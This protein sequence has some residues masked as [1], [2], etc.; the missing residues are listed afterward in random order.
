MSRQIR[1][2]IDQINADAARIAS[3]RDDL[4]S[5]MAALG[6][7]DPGVSNI[8]TLARTGLTCECDIDWDS[9]PATHGC[10]LHGMCENC[11]EY[12]GVC[13]DPQYPVS[14]HSNQRFR[15]GWVCQKCFECCSV[16]G[17]HQPTEGHLA[18]CDNHPNVIA[19][20]QEEQEAERDHAIANC[21]KFGFYCG[22][23]GKCMAADYAQVEAE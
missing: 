13:Y 15:N 21:G 4:A 11:M 10:K 5:D 20:R 7:I 18:N 6:P 19:R 12:L 14:R 9:R 1:R 3:L 16:C 17:N 8:A 22:I 23:C 2:E